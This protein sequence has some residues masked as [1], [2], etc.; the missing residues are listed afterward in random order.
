MTN[1]KTQKEVVGGDW[2]RIFEVEQLET[3]V[4]GQG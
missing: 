4:Y 1:E 3:S 2:R